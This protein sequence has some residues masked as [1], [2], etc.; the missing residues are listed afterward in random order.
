MFH[1]ENRQCNE[2]QHS[3][4]STITSTSAS[5]VC[6]LSTGTMCTSARKV[7]LIGNVVTVCLYPDRFCTLL[8]K[9]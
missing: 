3:I 7:E 2:H 1:F 8:L 9:S 5:T 4:T 6:S